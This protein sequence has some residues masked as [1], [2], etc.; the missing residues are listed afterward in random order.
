MPN[1]ARASWTRVLI[2]CAG[3]P[4]AKQEF[5]IALTELLART[6]RFELS[7]EIKMSQ[8]PEVGPLSVP[9]VFEAAD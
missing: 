5:R 1:R 9:M 2:S 3:M 8:M 6:K 7:G 4:I